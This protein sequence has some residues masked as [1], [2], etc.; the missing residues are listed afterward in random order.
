MNDNELNKYFVADYMKYMKDDKTKIDSLLRYAFYIIT[1]E[2]NEMFLNFAY[3][4]LIKY[5]ID[6]ED[7]KPLL[8]FAIIFGYYP[9]I[10]IILNK[11]NA[12]VDS[13]LINLLL[14][15]NIETN[16]LDNK[17]LTSGQ[18]SIF[19]LL[20]VDNDYS[21]VAPTSFGKTELMLESS[22]LS[23]KDAIII[24]PLVALLNQVKTDLIKISKEKK[25]DIKVITHHDIKPSLNYKNIYI[26]TQERCYELIKRKALSNISNLFIDEAHKLLGNGERSYKL[27]QIIFLL[28]KQH[29][30][31][32]KYYSPVLNNP[33]LVKI[34][35]L[36]N[37]PIEIIHGI[38]DMKN[39]NY[40]FYHDNKK[41]L[42][43]PNT[44]LMNS[45]FTFTD[46]TYLS[47][48][49][50]IKENSKNKNII[51]CNSPKILE[52]YAIEFSLELKEIT[53][54]VNV[55]QDLIDFIGEEYN[56][57]DTL[58]KGII[59]IH[60]EMPD[61]IKFYLLNLYKNC[62]EIKYIVTNSSIL[63]GVNTPSDNLFI[64][65]YKIGAKIMTPQDFINLSGRINRIN[66]IVSSGNL[67]RLICDIHFDASNTRKTAIRK[68]IINPAYG[69]M[70]ETP[71]NEYLEGT[72]K[73]DISD[74]F[75]TSLK[76]IKLID[77]EIDVESIFK[78]NEI[79]VDENETIRKSLL[80][81]L[82]LNNE[83]TNQINERLSNYKNIKTIKDLL[84]AISEIFK[85][86]NDDDISLA[87][88]CN[89][90]AINF[91]SMLLEWI[92]SG[93]TIREKANRMLSYYDN[94]D[95]SELIY[96]GKRGDIAAE[97][98]NG[99]LRISDNCKSIYTDKNGKHKVLKKVWV[100]NN[101]DN[102]KKLYNIF[103]VKLKI[104]ED[105]IAFKLMPFIETI[106]DIDEKIISEELYNTIKY[107]TN[108]LFEIEL[109]KEGISIYLARELNTD[110][111][112]QFIHVTEKGISV[113][114]KILQNFKGNDVLREELLLL[115]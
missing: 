33:E 99:E 88:L 73:S 11:Y 53:V 35:G 59:Y 30:I 18:Q 45:N 114:E 72:I 86:G 104:E 16:T 90:K 91:Y 32:V 43:L 78:V 51:F 9:I 89:E 46:N 84:K 66:N 54:D 15:F 96:V 19:S 34:K 92:I 74:E 48:F 69:I 100:R 75:E 95:K 81:G 8:E 41:E 60:G 68:R 49:E 109:V 70:E 111:N 103:I 26:L 39:Y 62:D 28:R 17:I 79:V 98:I 67:N 29:N 27:A 58:K 102:K 21:L 3:G 65:D 14:E 107:R 40:Y 64:Y 85:L 31:I 108:D 112:R 55:Y 24:V 36:Y 82:K 93:K 113:N 5:A 6:F 56:V 106:R 1:K 110:N 105:F 61:I 25:I 94:I 101:R 76:Q 13:K 44:A 10:D 22:L 63:E 4:I 37:N 87:R 115:I 50:Y 80:N 83:Q 52:E 12:K 97:L 42:Y 2:N 71:K 47:F 7:F 77:N 23:K 57:V 20:N 38:R